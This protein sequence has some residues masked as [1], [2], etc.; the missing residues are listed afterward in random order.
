MFSKHCLLSNVTFLENDKTYINVCMVD[1]FDK[2]EAY[3]LRKNYNFAEQSTLE[4][5]INN[6]NISMMLSLLSTYQDF[7]LNLT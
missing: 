6:K 3:E 4:S 1:V 7:F 2:V 5:F